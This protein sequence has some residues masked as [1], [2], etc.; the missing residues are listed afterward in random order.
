[1]KL[2]DIE[3]LRAGGLISISQAAAIASHFQLTGDTRSRRYL[4]AAFSCLGGLLV[5]GGIAML[6]AANWDEIPTIS[7]QIFAG[8]LMFALWLAGLAFLFKREPRPFLG[9]ALCFVGAGMLLL[10]LALYAQ[11]YQV[12]EPPHCAF[13]AWFLGIFL[14]PWIIHLRGVFALSLVAALAFVVSFFGE[15]EITV[16]DDE[17]FIIVLAF[18]TALS[19]LGIFLYSRQ[20]EASERSRG[21]AAIAS[22]VAFPTAILMAQTALYASYSFSTTSLVALAVASAAF[23]FA[24]IKHVFSLPRERRFGGFVLS[25][26]LFLVPMLPLLRAGIESC[27]LVPA[28]P[29]ELAFMI[30]LFA[31]GTAAMAYGA[32]ASQ[33]IYVNTG[34]LIVLLSAIAAYE[35]VVGSLTQSGAALVIAGAFLLAVGFFLEHGRRKLSKQIDAEDIPAALN[36]ALSAAARADVSAENAFR[37]DAYEKIPAPAAPRRTIPFPQKHTSTPT[38][39]DSAASA[40][41]DAPSPAKPRIPVPPK[42]AFATKN[43][44]DNAA[45]APQKSTALNDGNSARADGLTEPRA[46]DAS[47]ETKTP[48]NAEKSTDVPA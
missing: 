25:G 29:L 33:K 13:G 8:T 19:A 4:L 47:A 30:F 11:V 27:G 10:N 28:R 37:T 23:Y 26:L 35:K 18:M 1:M 44:S 43:P 5:L 21:Y 22:W 15:Q 36:T 45:A 32:R 39:T 3:E 2:S 16:F 34:A 14:I 42:S 7:K 12:F 46:A 6:I 48:G 31:Q 38:P 24:Q 17:G 40:K 20:S 9:E 41:N